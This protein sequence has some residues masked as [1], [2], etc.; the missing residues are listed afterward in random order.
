MTQVGFP[1]DVDGR[2][3]TADATPTEHVRDLVEALLFTTPG[4]RPMRPSLGAGLMALVLEPARDDLAASTQLLVQGAL[5]TWLGELIE[6]EA[7]EASGSEA[8][9]EVTVRYVV[10]ETGDRRRETFRQAAR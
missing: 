6:V 1:F 3:R 4:E 10:R 7:V 9:L 8:M 2:G 5:Q